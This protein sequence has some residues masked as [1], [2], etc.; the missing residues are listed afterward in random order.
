MAVVRC[1]AGE[2][3]L[4]GG[5]YVI[6]RAPA[7][8]IVVANKL[9]SRQHARLTVSTELVTIEDLSSGNGVYV[10]GRRVRIPCALNVGDRVGIGDDEIELKSFGVAPDV[11]A[12]IIGD[13]NRDAT[14]G[15]EEELAS[16]ALADPFVMLGQMALRALGKAGPKEA[17]TL[18]QPRLA[19][20]IQDAKQGQEIPP[21][22]REAAVKFAC[23]LA[24]G[25]CDGKWIDLALELLVQL[26]APCPEGSRE[27]LL[28]AVEA[29]RDL[30]GRRLEAYVESVQA[31]P[32][33][34]ER[35]RSI[36]H[37]HAMMDA[38]H[39]KH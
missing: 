27:L 12:T 33:S 22:R 13:R 24:I 17:A 20:L 31:M 15:R 39:D 5:R 8:D 23:K 3:C 34:I 2:F 28:E 25:T 10:N 26:G 4:G 19:G 21:A 14:S 32:R 38:F 16:T 11:E 1:P 18:L 30:D 35:I 7:S 6:G 36:Q 9:A 29:A 37:A